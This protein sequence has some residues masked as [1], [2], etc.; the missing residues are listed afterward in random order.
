MGTVG[1]ASANVTS[2][3]EGDETVDCAS[4]TYYSAKEQTF[5]FT[6]ASLNFIGNTL[7]TALT[8]FTGSC[9]K[10]NT[11]HTCTAKWVKCQFSP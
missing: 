6:A 11:I 5:R 9:S 2:D 8:Y 10:R 4:H 1:S 3:S 7:F